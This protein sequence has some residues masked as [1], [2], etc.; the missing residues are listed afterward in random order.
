MAT[1]NVVLTWSPANWIT[2]LIMVLV[3]FLVI[4][5]VTGGVMKWRASRDATS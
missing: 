3:G 2:V 1:E 4:G 5:A